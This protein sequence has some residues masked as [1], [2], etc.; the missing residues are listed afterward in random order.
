MNIFWIQR[1]SQAT[2]TEDT[3]ADRQVMQI[4]ASKVNSVEI[5]TAWNPITREWAIV[6]TL[7]FSATWKGESAV[8]R[9]FDE[10]LS[11]PTGLNL[12]DHPVT[13]LT[14]VREIRHALDRVQ[15]RITAALSKDI[16]C[17]YRLPTSVAQLL[18]LYGESGDAE[19][20]P[21][22]EMKEEGA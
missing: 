12:F 4:P 2:G 20:K 6:G 16:E 7:D 13:L 5:N 22:E 10:T 15:A 14:R 9:F 11:F 8:V 18:D 21:V 1:H 17:V 3:V 19:N